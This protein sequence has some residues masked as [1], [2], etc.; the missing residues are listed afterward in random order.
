[1][2]RFKDDLCMTSA[3]KHSPLEINEFLLRLHSCFEFLSIEN[4]HDRVTN[5]PF[6][7]GL[8]KDCVTFALQLVS[9][10]L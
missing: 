2:F 7:I 3:I 8:F 1:M 6:L 9:L 4:S 10:L 5:V